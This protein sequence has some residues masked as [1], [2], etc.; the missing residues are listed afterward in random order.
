MASALFVG[1]A[2]AVYGYYLTF[3]D[4]RG[5]FSILISVQLV[6]SMLIGG[7][8]TLWGP[9]LGAFLIEWLNEMANNDWGGG[10]TRLF[11]FGGLLVAIV[12][13]LPKGILPAL[14]SLLSWRRTHGK[15]GLVGAR[16]GSGGGLAATKLGRAAW[17]E[18]V[19][20]NGSSQ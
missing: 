2:G 5:M 9:V 13:F 12:I 7:K 17:R 6:L 15:A 14:E 18:R 10:N 20:T 8:A 4:P 1:M 11:L 19:V 16:I 3:I